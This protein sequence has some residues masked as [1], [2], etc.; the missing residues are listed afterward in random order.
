MSYFFCPAVVSLPE[1]SETLSV[2]LSTANKLLRHAN[3]DSE[4]LCMRSV[5]AVA[6]VRD[7]TVPSFALNWRCCCVVGRYTEDSAACLSAAG[8]VSGDDAAAAAAAAGQASVVS[9]CALALRWHVNHLQEPSLR[10]F[11]CAVST[12]ACFCRCLARATWRACARRVW[13]TSPPAPPL[14]S[15]AVTCFALSAGL[16]TSPLPSRVGRCVC[17][18]RCAWK[19]R[20]ANRSG[21]FAQVAA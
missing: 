17:K 14:A 4:A 13:R 12:R 16:T 5:L 21:G 9:R 2:P 10:P 19:R 3:W 8:V 18:M 6:F 7:L 11:A 1:V 15:S 20:P